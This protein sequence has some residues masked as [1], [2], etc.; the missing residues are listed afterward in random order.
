MLTSVEIQPVVAELEFDR[1]FCRTQQ[2]IAAAISDRKGAG[3]RPRWPPKHKQGIG[4]VFF[5]RR[6]RKKEVVTLMSKR[7]ATDFFPKILRISSIRAVEVR[8]FEWVREVSASV[9]G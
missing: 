3:G 1:W 7:N 6:L 9:D 8:D 4:R 2:Q 5:F